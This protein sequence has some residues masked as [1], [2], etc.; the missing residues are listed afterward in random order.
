[1]LTKKRKQ[2]IFKSACYLDFV[3]DELKGLY[4]SDYTEEEVDEFLAD[5][6][7]VQRV[8][9]ATDAMWKLIELQLEAVRII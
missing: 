9:E 7:A 4:E 2:E 1:M 6:K 5:E 8:T 3:H